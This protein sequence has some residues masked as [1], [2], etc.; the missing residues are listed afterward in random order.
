[1]PN[2]I[3]LIL[4]TLSRSVRPKPYPRIIAKSVQP[5]TLPWRLIGRQWLRYC[6]RYSSNSFGC[7]RWWKHTY[8]LCVVRR[9]R[10]EAVSCSHFS[11]A[12]SCPRQ[13]NCRLWPDGCQYGGPRSRVSRHGNTRPTRQYCSILS[14]AS[15]VRSTT[16]QSLGHLQTVARSGAS[17]CQGVMPECH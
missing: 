8:T 9:L 6:R 12:W 14:A 7:R 1:M 11:L 16:Q 3:P 13:H 5:C 15:Q 10:L 17:L 4:L 2:S